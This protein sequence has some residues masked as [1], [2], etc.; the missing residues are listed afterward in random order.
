[1]R[2]HGYSDESHY[3]VGRYRSV[4]LVSI[5]ETHSEKCD[6]QLRKILEINNVSE[7]AWKDL[8]SANVRKVAIEWLP[9]VFDLACQRNLRVDVLCW[10]THDRRHNVPGRDDIKNLHRMY[11]HLLRNVL[12]KRWPNEFDWII[13]PDEQSALRWGS[14]RA[15]LEYSRE[16]RTGSKNIFTGLSY[17]DEFHG[18]RFEPQRSHEKPLVQVA[19]LFAGVMIFSCE[20]FERFLCAIHQRQSR[21]FDSP[22]VKLT[23]GDRER[24]QVLDHLDRLCKKHSFGVSLRTKKRLQTFDPDDPARSFNFWW[25]ESQYSDDRAPTRKSMTDVE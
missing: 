13:C 6:L 21:M 3:N 2:V 23:V 11:Y 1:M 25:Y 7:F 8:R 20:H 24:C 18:L 14:L 19:D 16:G 9:I 10:D 5:L 22:P 4:A 17:T 12:T 15:F